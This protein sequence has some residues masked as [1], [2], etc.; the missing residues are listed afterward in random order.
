M[1]QS[2][3]LSDELIKTG[4]ALTGAAALQAREAVLGVVRRFADTDDRSAIAELLAGLPKPQYESDSTDPAR[5]VQVDEVGQRERG[6]LVNRRF[7]TD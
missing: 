6:R 2:V 7:V 4:A 3:K 5:I 1:P